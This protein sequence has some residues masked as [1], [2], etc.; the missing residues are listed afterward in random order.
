MVWI[1]R[2]GGAL[3]VELVVEMF[4]RIL[5]T[6]LEKQRLPLFYPKIWV[7]IRVLSTGSTQLSLSGVV[8][9]C[10]PGPAWTDFRKVVALKA[11]HTSNWKFCAAEIQHSQLI[12]FSR[13]G[14]TYVRHMRQTKFETPVRTVS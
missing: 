8:E 5:Y 10:W 4:P 6:N 7:G 9:M 14:L 2:T 3:L 12:G 11:H 1:P 13:V